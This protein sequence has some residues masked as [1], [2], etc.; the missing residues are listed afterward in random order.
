MT[1][2]QVLTELVD[3]L[4]AGSFDNEV[5]TIIYGERLIALSKKDGGVRPIAIGYTLSRLVAKCAN[6][7]DIADEAW[8]YSHNS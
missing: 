6:R 5:N 1:V 4:L 8:S 2:L 7:H 3:L